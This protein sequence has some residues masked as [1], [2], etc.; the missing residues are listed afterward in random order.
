MQHQISCFYYS[1]VPA[2][3]SQW[4][5]ADLL[6]STSTCCYGKHMLLGWCHVLFSVH[7]AVSRL[8]PTTPKAEKIS[9]NAG[10]LSDYPLLKQVLSEF[11][12]FFHAP[13]SISISPKPMWFDVS[14]FRI[15]HAPWKNPS[16]SSST[17]FG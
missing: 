1:H 11:F 6:L 17:L 9:K 3:T 15:S 16:T 13:E 5:S 2:T 12:V 4:M 7:L 14:C 8:T 10:K